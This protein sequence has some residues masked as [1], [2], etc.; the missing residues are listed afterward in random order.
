MEIILWPSSSAAFSEVFCLKLVYLC[1][2][3]SPYL[4]PHSPSQLSCSWLPPTQKATYFAC[5]TS[6]IQRSRP[7]S[8][9]ARGE[10]QRKRCVCS[11]LSLTVA[12]GHSTFWMIDQGP[13]VMATHLSI[14]VDGS[15]DK[16]R[17]GASQRH[18]LSLSIIG[19]NLSEMWPCHGWW[20]ITDNVQPCQWFFNCI[21]EIFAFLCQIAALH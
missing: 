10:P 7:Q 13:V 21:S 3:E 6:V 15:I 12:L 8:G 4:R 17:W 5:K 1:R 11:R 9:G 14:R 18:K 2:T 19:G 20:S 16:G